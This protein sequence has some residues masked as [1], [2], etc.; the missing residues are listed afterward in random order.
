MATKYSEFSGTILILNVQPHFLIRA[1]V[2]VRP[3]VLNFGQK[4]GL[5]SRGP[6]NSQLFRAW[7]AERAHSLHEGMNELRTSPPPLRTVVL[8]IN[9]KH[10]E[11]PLLIA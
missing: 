2:F 5:P 3:W 6:G 1:F 4:C 10:P 7:K 8:H 9:L 11:I